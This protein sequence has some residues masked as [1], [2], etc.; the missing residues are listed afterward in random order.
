MLNKF[1]C[2]IAMSLMA[3]SGCTWVKPATGAEE[4]S[5]LKAQHVEHCRKLGTASAQTKEKV[6]FVKRN[7]KKVSDELLML[8]KNEAA[9]MGGNVIISQGEQNEGKQS[10]GVFDCAK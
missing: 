8:A 5:L 1:V 4:V 3:L 10:F 2:G 6:A 7:T 9:S